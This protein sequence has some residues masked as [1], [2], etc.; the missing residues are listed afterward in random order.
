MY[1]TK[2]PYLP[3]GS[4]G[5]LSDA[6]RIEAGSATLFKQAP[7]TANE[8]LIGAIDHIDAVFGNGYARAHPELVAAVV[9]ACALDFGAAVIAR[10]FEAVADSAK[11]VAGAIEAVDR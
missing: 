3:F 7:M 10:A 11:E 2:K 8:Y 1:Q 4:S 9:Q 5:P 6:M